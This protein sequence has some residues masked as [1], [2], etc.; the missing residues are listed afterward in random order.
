MSDTAK[1]LSLILGL[2]TLAFGAYYLYTQFFAGPAVDTNQQTM[3]EMLNNTLVF[4]ERRETLES[5]E[6]DINFFED[7]RILSL[8][9]YD[10]P[11]VEQ[12]VGR[13]NPFDNPGNF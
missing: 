4:I 2:I 9:S 5:I 1:N 13:P 3:D 6:L 7:S 10:E 11:I 8:Q 12:P